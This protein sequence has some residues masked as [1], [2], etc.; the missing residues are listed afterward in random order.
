[1]SRAITEL[2][3]FK[4]EVC[5]LEDLISNE[6]WEL[7]EHNKMSIEGEFL[8]KMAHSHGVFYQMDSYEKKMIE[9]PFRKALEETY[10]S[11]R[12]HYLGEWIVV[13]KVGLLYLAAQPK[14]VAKFLPMECCRFIG[15]M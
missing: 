13:G 5:P 1:M 7:I 8:Q 6:Q 12:E 2:I 15:L 14:K 11:W 4:V 9:H 3:P 10:A